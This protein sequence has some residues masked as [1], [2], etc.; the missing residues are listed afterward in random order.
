LAALY[1]H[2]LPALY[3]ATVS[4]L[5]GLGRQLSSVVRRGYAVSLDESERGVAGIAVPLWDSQGRTHGAMAV[6][7]HSSRCPGPRVHQIGSMLL[8]EARK[9]VETL[10]AVV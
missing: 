10:D 4:D 8:D 7:L 9:L 1:P 3:A 2:G 5:P 6:A